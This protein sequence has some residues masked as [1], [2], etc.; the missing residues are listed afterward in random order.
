MNTFVVLNPFRRAILQRL[1]V[2]ALALMLTACA[3]GPDYQRPPI[4]TGL[5]Y[6]EVLAASP[7]SPAAVAASQG[8]VQAQPGDD[9]LRGDSWQLFNDAVL[10]ALMQALQESKDRKSVV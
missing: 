6:K 1:A 9:A 5:A 10:S 2:P 7:S 4:D 8:W 3:M